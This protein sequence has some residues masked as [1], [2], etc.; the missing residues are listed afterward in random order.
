MVPAWRGDLDIPQQAPHT[1]IH[2]RTHDEKDS[3]PIQACS[4]FEIERVARHSQ[5]W[6]IRFGCLF[7]KSLLAARQ[8]ECA[9]CVYDRNGPGPA[10]SEKFVE[11]VHRPEDASNL[12]SL[13]FGKGSFGFCVELEILNEANS[14]ADFDPAE[15]MSSSYAISPV[16]VR[17]KLCNEM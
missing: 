14:K 17:T 13:Q 11:H 1:S 10:T 3:E 15:M 12:L 2:E 4:G 5:L 9:F 7:P 16:S 6:Y 8:G